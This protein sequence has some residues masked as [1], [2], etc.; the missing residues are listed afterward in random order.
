M[1]PEDGS[2]PTADRRLRIVTYNVHACIGS[3][4]EFLPQRI[5]EVLAELRADFIGIQELEDRPFGDESVSA[6]LAR[7]LGMHAYRGATLKRQDAHYGNLLLSKEPAAA[8]CLHDISVPG[9]EPRGIIEARYE[10]F[11]HRI[12]MLVTHFGL[13]SAERRKQV[14]DLLRVIDGGASDIDVLAGDFNEWRPVSYTVRALKKRIGAVPRRGTWPAS[15]PL[16]AL[17][18]ICVSPETVH[19]DVY[20][21]NTELARLASDHL[22][23]VCDLI[24]RGA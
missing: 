14:R 4:G 10:L 1:F 17:D 13:R 12:R 15:R 21:V 7:A 6:Y 5:C 22:P 16:L 19:R 24:V 9:R 23:L 2:S 18:S 3:D 20:V 8:T 11:G